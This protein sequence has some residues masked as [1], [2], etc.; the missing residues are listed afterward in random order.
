VEADGGEV[1]LVDIVPGYSTS[2]I[3]A[4]SRAAAKR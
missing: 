2:E 3:V 1:I 4:R